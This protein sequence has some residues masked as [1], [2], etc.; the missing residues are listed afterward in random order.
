M[1]TASGRLNQEGR[2]RY[3]GAFDTGDYVLS[4]YKDGTYLLSEITPLT[5]FDTEEL[6]WVGRLTSDTVISAIYFDGE[7]EWTMLKRF[8]I[9]T[10]TT[11]Q[12]YKF[13]TEHP[14]SKLY[15]A[16]ADPK[17]EVKYSIKTANK[18]M[19]HTIVPSEFI[20]VKGWKALGNKLTEYKIL[21]IEE[22]AKDE[23]APVEAEEETVTLALK[24]NA[25]RPSGPP[26][27]KVIK[28]QGSL[29]PE[30]VPEKPVK[31]VKS[32]KQV[33]PVKKLK[34]ASKAKP[35]KATKA[36]RSAKKKAAAKPPKTK[37]A[38]SGKSAAGKK[39]KSK[40]GSN[41]KY[42]AGDTIEW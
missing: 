5:K 1:D 23:N 35:V 20:D 2:G 11:G 3:L 21:S 33:K 38:A 12:R 41:G 39:G 19:E 24:A 4:I 40:A 13:I 10:S 9:E 17:V 18:K 7:K 26:P 6:E 25:V 37:K 22:I 42:K 31:P 8:Q 28:A 15:Y 14:K 34:P 32:V 16:T 29:F 36:D 27:Q 30:L